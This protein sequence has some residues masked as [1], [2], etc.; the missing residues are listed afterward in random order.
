MIRRLFWLTLGAAAGISG[1]RRATALARSISPGPRARELTRFAG[2]VRE[3]MEI[4]KQQQ[5]GRGSPVLEGRR[6]SNGRAN[7]IEDGH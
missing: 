4:Y 1:Y 6:T 3:G 7:Q 5:P 2:D